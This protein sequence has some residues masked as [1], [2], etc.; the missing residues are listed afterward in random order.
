[1]HISGFLAFR[2]SAAL[3]ALVEKVIKDAPEFTPDTLFVDGNGILHPQQCGLACHI[4]FQ[5]NIPTIGVA[6]NLFHLDGIKTEKNVL[7]NLSK[8]GDYIYI[9]DKEEQIVG[10]VQ[11]PLSK[12]FF[13]K[14]I[15]L[16]QLIVYIRYSCNYVTN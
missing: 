11:L 13:V 15:S 12:I 3:I 8:T 6:K 9:R 14:F 5:T 16:L 7:Q 2:E 1:M 10:M 4:G